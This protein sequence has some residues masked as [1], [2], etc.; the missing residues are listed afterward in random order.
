[1]ELYNQAT[2]YGKIVAAI[3]LSVL[4]G[5]SQLQSRH[6]RAR[7]G[8]PDSQAGRVLKGTQDTA[9]TPA[10]AHCGASDSEGAAAQVEINGPAQLIEIAGT[11]PAMT[12]WRVDTH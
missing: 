6:G 4:R 7:A 3:V 11:S 12:P 8:H 1:M 2:A 5:R 9:F 10:P